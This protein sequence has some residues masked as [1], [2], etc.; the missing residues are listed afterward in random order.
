MEFVCSDS[1]CNSDYHYWVEEDF[2]QIGFK[3]KD[4]HFTFFYSSN[5]TEFTNAKQRIIFNVPAIFDVNKDN[6]L[7]VVNRCQKL[8]LLQ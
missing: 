5:V 6:Y 7:E 4:W 2:S 8:Q 1:G 3:I